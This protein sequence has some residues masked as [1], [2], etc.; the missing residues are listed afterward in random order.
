MKQRTTCLPDILTL[1]AHPG[2]EPIKR[3]VF[4]SDVAT[5]DQDL[6]DGC[7]GVAVPARIGEI[8]TAL[9]VEKQASRALD[10]DHERLDGVGDIGDRVS[11]LAQR[12]RVDLGAGGIW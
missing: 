3:H 1:C 4:E 5:L 8:E 11:A 7:V 12:A 9:L 10:V 6:A 2:L